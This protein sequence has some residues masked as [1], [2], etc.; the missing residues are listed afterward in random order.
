MKDSEMKNTVSP[1]M[2][3]P[4][5]PAEAQAGSQCDYLTVS[6]RGQ[7]VRNTTIFVVVMFVLGILSLGMMVKKTRPQAAQAAA[8]DTEE[9]NI[10]AAISRLTGVRSEMMDRMDDILVKFSEFTSVE[11]V[12]VSELAKNPFQLE[13]LMQN[14]DVEIVET[15]PP[16]RTVMFKQQM[17]KE[18][19]GLELLSIMNSEQ[20]LRCVIGDLIVMEGD[21]VKNFELLRVLERQVELQW[22]PQSTDLEDVDVT[23]LRTVLKLAE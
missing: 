22:H 19:D 20:G 13:M 11:Q 8:A 5:I 15:I 21:R 7:H 18:A 6:G 17:L 14:V 16:D 3:E 9:A 1:F 4:E 2:T 23:Q 10:E 12:T